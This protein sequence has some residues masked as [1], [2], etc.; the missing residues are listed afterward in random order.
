MNS[1]IIH[2]NKNNITPLLPER[3]ETNMNLSWFT[4]TTYFVLL[5][6]SVYAFIYWVLFMIN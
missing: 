4:I 6:G 3:N 1:I 2:N 5:F